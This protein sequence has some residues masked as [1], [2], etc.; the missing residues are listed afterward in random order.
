MN[1][2]T[3]SF[4]FA[5]MPAAA[6]DSWPFLVKAGL[7]GLVGRQTGFDY[8]N[9][10]P[11]AAVPEPATCSLFMAGLAGLAALGRRRP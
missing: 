8:W 11:L 2:P 5:A 3:A 10:A 4:A 1:Q 6:T 7:S 9:E